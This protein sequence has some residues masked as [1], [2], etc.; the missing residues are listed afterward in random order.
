MATMTARGRARRELLLRA[1]AGLVAERGFHAVGIA[2]IG[3]AAGVTGSAIYRH[4]GS[5]EAILVAL[6]DQ[7]LDELLVGARRAVELSRPLD[8]LIDRHAEFAMRERALI[9][10]WSTESQNLPATD[11]TRLRRKQRAYADLWADV[12][13][14]MRPDASR[15]SAIATIHAVFGLLNSVADYAP[16]IAHVELKSLLCRSARNVLRG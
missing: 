10:V 4:F 2:D 14:A 16:Q 7:V 1:A 15:P 11:R 3:A 12:L 6:F 9:K 13:V 8:E 5:K